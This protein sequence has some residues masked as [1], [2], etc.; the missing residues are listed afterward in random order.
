[1]NVVTGSGLVDCMTAPRVMRALA[2][3]TVAVAY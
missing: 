1:M 2:W 3:M